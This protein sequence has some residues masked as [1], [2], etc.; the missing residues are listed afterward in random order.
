MVD[1]VLGPQPSSA[2]AFRNANFALHIG[3]IENDQGLPNGT[4]SPAYEY[5]K[6]TDYAKTEWLRA[7]TGET[8]MAVPG[9]NFTDLT[10]ENRAAI[11]RAEKKWC[12]QVVTTRIM[13]DCIMECAP[14][15]QQNAADLIEELAAAGLEV[16]I[17]TGDPYTAN[18][19]DEA[20]PWG[21]INKAAS[22]IFIQVAVDLNDTR[23]ARARYL[24]TNAVVTAWLAAGKSV[25]V[26][27]FDLDGKQAALAKSYFDSNLFA[28]PRVYGHY[29]PS[30][31]PTVNV[32]LQIPGGKPVTD[33]A[34]AH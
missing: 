4:K 6:P 31:S 18:E 30:Y 16:M 1:L 34:P 27:I 7:V 21:R 26:G 22:V 11:V 15:Q 13:V 20:T 12:T 2:I 3:G 14:G 10:P 8:W 33:P 28:S 19:K 9:T 32:G 5:A 25:I 23:D 24:L 29:N 17:N